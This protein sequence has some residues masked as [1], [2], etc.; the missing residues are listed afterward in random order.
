MKTLKEL[1]P[2][3]YYIK[4]SYP[5]TIYPAEEGGYV[6]EIEDL[7]G[8]IIEACFR[9]VA[10]IFW[11]HGGFYNPLAKNMGVLIEHDAP[12]AQFIG[13]SAFEIFVLLLQFEGHGIDIA[14]EQAGQGVA[15]EK[16]Q[17]QTAGDYQQGD[18][19]PDR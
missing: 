11:G 7:P 17:R 16:I 14:S 3:E 13:G 1:K 12:P 18:F 6:A 9:G 10:S 8:C 4:L 15:P 2:I 5:I 19:E